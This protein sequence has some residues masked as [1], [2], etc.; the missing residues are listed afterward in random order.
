MDTISN[1]DQIRK[2]DIGLNANTQSC[3]CVSNVP[4]FKFPIIKTA[5]Y[6]YI[7]YLVTIR[8]FNLEF[9]Q[10]YNFLNNIR[11]VGMKHVIKK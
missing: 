3:V 10:I 2:C 7:L 1:K 4:I 9:K 5:E 6:I 11:N 8:N